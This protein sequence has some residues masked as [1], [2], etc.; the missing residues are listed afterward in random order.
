MQGVGG[1]EGGARTRQEGPHA[2]DCAPG[3]ADRDAGS[4]SDAGKRL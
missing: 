2:V 4:K 1:T 3:R